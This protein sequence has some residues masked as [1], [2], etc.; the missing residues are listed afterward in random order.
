M[1][2]GLHNFYKIAQPLA[3]FVDAKTKSTKTGCI[4]N[5]AQKERIPTSLTIVHYFSFVNSFGATCKNSIFEVSSRLEHE[6]VWFCNL[7]SIKTES[8]LH[9]CRCKTSNQNIVQC[10]AYDHSRPLGF[11]SRTPMTSKDNNHHFTLIWICSDVINKL[12]N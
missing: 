7:I 10:N 8:Y 1:V 3:F 11:S 6:L 12:K 4:K 9:I 2:K 5:Q